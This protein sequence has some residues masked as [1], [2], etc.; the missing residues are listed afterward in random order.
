[1]CQ[2]CW[3]LT[4]PGRTPVKL[5]RGLQDE[6]CCVCGEPTRDGIYIR[7]DPRFVPHPREDKHAS[8]DNG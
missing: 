1:M 4:N 5:V 8:D 7:A 6:T 2:S 3:D